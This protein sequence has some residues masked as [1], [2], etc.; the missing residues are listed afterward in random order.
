MLLYN[1]DSIYDA[2]GIPVTNLSQLYENMK[3]WM[4]IK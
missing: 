4:G 1:Y 2:D 3:M